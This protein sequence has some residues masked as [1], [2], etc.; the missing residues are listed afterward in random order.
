MMGRRNVRGVDLAAALGI[1]QPQ[2]S[3]RVRGR[4]AWSLHELDTL[5]DLFGCDVTDLLPTRAITG[6]YLQWGLA[7]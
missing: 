4:L 5:A 2:V 6:G 3:L 7:A 1:S